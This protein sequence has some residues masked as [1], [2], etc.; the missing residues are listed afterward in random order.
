MALTTDERLWV[1]SQIGDSEPPSDAD[2]DTMHDRLDTPEAVVVEVLEKRLAEYEARPA[3]F[4]VPGEYSQSTAA[5]IEAL[6]M[7]LRRVRGAQPIPLTRY[8]PDR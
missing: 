7:R 5:N 4:S 3:S 6:R 1:R 8:G 2:L